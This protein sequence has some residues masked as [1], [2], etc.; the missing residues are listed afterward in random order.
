MSKEKP[1]LNLVSNNT[2]SE[3]SSNKQVEVLRDTDNKTSSYENRKKVFRVER[4]ETPKAK[5]TDKNKPE[6]K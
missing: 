5:A 3:Q 6:Q 4:V 1:E 2:V